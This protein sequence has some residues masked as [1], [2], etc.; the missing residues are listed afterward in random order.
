MTHST[1]TPP[2]R[3]GLDQATTVVDRALDEARR[4]ALKPLTVVVLD[5]GGHLLCAKREDNSGILRFE[6]AFGKAWGALGM[7]RSSRDLEEMSKARPVFLTSLAAASG[8]RLVPV[9]GG[10]LIL[11]ANGS[12]IGAAGASG[13]TSEADEQCVLYGIAAAGLSSS[14]AVP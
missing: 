6:I 4:L 5:A 14:P 13:D 11:D 8:G 9:A 3:L 1:T 10:A 12:V 7:G 2:P